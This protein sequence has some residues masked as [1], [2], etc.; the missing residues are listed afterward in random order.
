MDLRRYLR[1]AACDGDVTKQTVEKAATREKGNRAE[2]GSDNGQGDDDDDDDD[3]NEDRRKRRKSK[4]RRSSREEGGKHEVVLSGEE[5]KLVKAMLSLGSEK[6]SQTQKDALKAVKEASPALYRRLE[7]EVKD[8][9]SGNGLVAAV[10]KVEKAPEWSGTSLPGG[11]GLP[12]WKRDFEFDPNSPTNDVIFIALVTYRDPQCPDSLVSAFERASNPS[13]VRIGVVQQNRATD[14]DCFETYCRKV[15]KDC[16]PSQVRVIRISDTEAQGVMV[17][18]FL[19]STLWSGERWYLQID[20]HSGFAYAWDDMVIKSA[21]ATGYERTVLSHHPPD[22]KLWPN[23]MGDNVINICRYKWDDGGLPR[24]SSIMANKKAQHISKPFPGIFIGAGF[25]FGRSQWIID[26]PFD[27][28][29]TFLFSG[30]ELLLSVCLF[31]KG[32][33]I[34]NPDVL[35][36]WHHYTRNLAGRENPSVPHLRMKAILRLKYLFGIVSASEVPRDYLKNLAPFTMGNV[37]T[38]EQYWKYAG[39]DWQK[40]PVNEPFCNMIDYSKENLVRMRYPHHFEELPGLVPLKD[41]FFDTVPTV[42]PRY[43][44]TAAPLDRHLREKA[45]SVPH[46]A[47]GEQISHEVVA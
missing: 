8:A 29:L 36:V 38:R 18:R 43:K 28:H 32:W 17:A 26:C 4:R 24:F 41:Y 35:P 15:G 45:D 30:E 5:R 16:R 10:S 3:S 25:V 33:N 19:A 12:G 34:Y 27:P 11:R 31:T 47:V 6:L 13:R 40:K 9:K 23:S 7:A 1:A 44:S 42:P 37:R 14:L 22:M 21:L 20:A 46:V 2:D 39:L